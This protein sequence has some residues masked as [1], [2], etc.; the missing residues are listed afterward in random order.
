MSDSFVETTSKSWISRIG[1]SILGV[2]FG[3]LLF[4]GA[5]V[6]LFWNE[7]RAI[8]TAR[9][10]AEGG[11]V[12]VDVPPDSVD[13]A[14][15]GHLIHVSGNAAAAASLADSTFGV[16]AVALR[17]VRTA[18]MYQWEET[19]HEETHKSVGG[20]EQTTTTYTYD[21]VWS[22]KAID[23]NH[24]RQPGN[25]ANPGKN[26]DRLNVAAADAKLGAFALGAPVLDLLPTDQSLRVDAEGTDKIRRI[27]DAQ[28]SDGAI[29]IGANPS[30]PQ[31]GD[32]RISYDIAPNGPVSIIGRQSGSGISQY[33][34]RAGDRLLMAEPGTHDAT[35]M[36]KEA[37]RNNQILTWVLRAIGIA[38]IWLGAFLVL[39]P[40]AVIGD[41]VPLIGDVIGAA[42]GLVALAIAIA[43]G[44]TV[45]AIAWF[46]YRPLVSAIVIAIGIGLGF[47]L[48]RLAPRRRTPPA[49]AAAA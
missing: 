22:E 37:Q 4:I 33:Q 42:A 6:L 39:G 38:M 7:G 14:N 24:F 15:D 46:F 2:L 1:Q 30:E 25:H 19:K 35:A 21:K 48:H 44:S 9:S 47:A 27:P 5:I 32:Y 8:Q 26:Y 45:I 40:L 18:K 20:S 36:F 29:Y 16:S 13:T 11:K 3:V 34:T 43:A 28:V 31:V 12:V 49:P 10:I 17:F 23:S 41:V